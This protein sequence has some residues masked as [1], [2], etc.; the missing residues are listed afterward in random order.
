[1]S[2]V[3]STGSRTPPS[4]RGTMPR[5]VT[6]CTMQS[7]LGKENKDHCQHGGC[8]SG[9]SASYGHGA[10]NCGGGGCGGH[11]HTHAT[12]P[13]SH[14]GATATT[15]GGVSVHNGCMGHGHSHHN[16]P[17]HALNAPCTRDTRI[18]ET[19]QKPTEIIGQKL[20]DILDKMKDSTM[21]KING[22]GM[23]AFGSLMESDDDSLTYAAMT[24]PPFRGLSY[25]MPEDA[26]Q[27]KSYKTIAEKAVKNK[28][29][30][31]GK[32]ANKAAAAAAAIAADDEKNT[33]Q[34]ARLWVSFKCQILSL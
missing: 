7:T 31:K 33:V 34:F 6:T 15:P 13:H 19:V 4:T 29:N 2:D 11:Q 21:N 20:N 9:G 22:I 27:A 16:R 28:A 1:M 24:V 30:K 10:S 25:S 8:G 14:Q 3:S 5:S 17:S 32:A 12:S 18:Y 23:K 26:V